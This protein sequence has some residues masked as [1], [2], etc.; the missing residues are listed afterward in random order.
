[1]KHGRGWAVGLVVAGLLAGGCSDEAA[2]RPRPVSGSPTTSAGESASSS[3]ST[4]TSTSEPATDETTSTTTAPADDAVG[5]E[6]AEGDPLRAEIETAYR[7]AVQ[8]AESAASVP[9]TDSP[10][11]ARWNDGPMLEK[12]TSNIAAL[13]I[14][15]RVVREPTPSREQLG[16]VEVRVSGEMATVETCETDDAVVVEQRTG[17]VVNDEVTAARFRSRLKLGSRWQLVEREV[18]AEEVVGSCGE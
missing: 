14:Q 11:L 7:D 3:G 15:G 4:G 17:A 9:T 2:D 8:A 16:F 6:L 5:R 10:E 1:M 13:V 18:V 12:W